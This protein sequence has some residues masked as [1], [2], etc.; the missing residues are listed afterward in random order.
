MINQHRGAANRLGFSVQLSCMR[1]PGVTL[2]AGVEPPAALLPCVAWQLN[3]DPALWKEYARRAQTRREH[4]LELQ[5]VLNLRPLTVADYRPAVLA[6]VDLAMQTDKGLV[7]AQALVEYLRRRAILLPTANV[8]ERIC[9]EAVRLP[10]SR[11][12]LL[13]L[14]CSPRS[15]ASVARATTPVDARRRRLGQRLF[16]DCTG[17]GAQL[18]FSIRC[19][20]HRVR[21]IGQALFGVTSRDMSERL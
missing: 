1:Y 21:E 2:S 4:L 8:I 16:S 18:L 14:H 10:A 15:S 19:D 7:L 3:I 17:H 11:N 13:T 9:A 20:T 6:L 12:D 5:A